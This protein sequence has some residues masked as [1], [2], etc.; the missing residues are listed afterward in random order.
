MRLAGA[1]ENKDPLYPTLGANPFPEVADLFC[2]LPSPVSFYQPEA[3]NVGLAT[4]TA[5][6]PRR[7]ERRHG[8]DQEALLP[9]PG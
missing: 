4:T 9:F 5:T 8:G 2:R 1:G 6:S 3:A 7:R